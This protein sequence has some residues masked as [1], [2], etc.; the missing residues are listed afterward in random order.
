MA[1]R[2]A[3]NNALNIPDDYGDPTA[4]VRSLLKEA[5]LRQDDLR[6]AETR[7]LD[8]GIATEVRR[9]DGKFLDS[10]MKY[11]I[12]FSAAKEALN[13]ALVA[14]DKQVAVALDGTK[15]SIR[16]EKVAT[17]KRFDLLGEKIDGVT[18][19]LNKNVGSAG[20]Y[21][22]HTDL[23]IALDK[24]QTSIEIALRPVI[25]FMNTQTGQAKGASSL[26]GY[27]LGGIG[28]ISLILTIVLTLSKL[29]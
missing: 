17:D 10:D 16:N 3:H 26:W 8:Q 12:Q 11:Q 7:R 6:F 18:D 28:L 1:K 24:L 21:V 15:E 5:I 14:A 13:I 20:V 27:I 2:N 29:P 9:V 22:T 23:T 19:V 4:N 25:T